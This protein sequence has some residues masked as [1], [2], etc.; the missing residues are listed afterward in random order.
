[1]NERIVADSSVCGS[2][3]CVKGTRIPVKVILS[4][5]ATGESAAE[6]LANFPV[7]K[8]RRHSSRPRVRLL[9]RGQTGGVKPPILLDENVSLA[10]ASRLRSLGYEVVAIAYTSLMPLRY[11]KYLTI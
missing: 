7:R 3:P 5:L 10:L 11:R 8:G 4:H 9:S 6:V 2:E 1:M